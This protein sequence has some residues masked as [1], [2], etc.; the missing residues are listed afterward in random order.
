MEKYSSTTIYSTI[1]RN[2]F[3]LNFKT[4]PAHFPQIPSSEPT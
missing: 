2:N 4:I 3:Q 1:S